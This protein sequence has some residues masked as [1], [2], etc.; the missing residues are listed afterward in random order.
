MKRRG[1]TQRVAMAAAGIAMVTSL[2]LSGAGTASA[3]AAPAPAPAGN[4][5]Q[6]DVQWTVSFNSAKRCQ[7]VFFF[8]TT[9]KFRSGTVQGDK[10]AWTG[11]GSKITMVWKHGPDA[12]LTFSGTFNQ[13][14]EEFS[15]TFG[16]TDAGD[17]GDVILETDPFC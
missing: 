4:H 10:G 9:H 11:G 3:A 1:M 13:S 8:T 17:T 15:G 16:G 14:P 6:D 7:R 5:I 12:G 2:G